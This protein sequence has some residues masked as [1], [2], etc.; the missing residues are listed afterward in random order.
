MSRTYFKEYLTAQEERRLFRTLAAR[1]GPTAERDLAWM[2]ALRYTGVRIDAFSRLTVGHA[3]QVVKTFYLTLEPA[4]QKRRKGHTIYVCKRGRQAF[5]RL[6]RL[7]RQQGRG[8][9]PDAPLVLSR[10]GG[11]LSVRAYQ[12]R[13]SYWDAEAGLHLGLS[14]HWFRHTL[15]KHLMK[16]SEAR[17]PQLIVMAALGHSDRR[18]TDIYTWPDKEDME[19]E[20]E[21]AA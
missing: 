18:S 14:P 19:L 2:Q 5:A 10:K 21:R 15:A 1:Q 12:E 7:H 4:I 6:I 13:C 17:D 11:P 20:L 8:L 9:D 3:L 16:T